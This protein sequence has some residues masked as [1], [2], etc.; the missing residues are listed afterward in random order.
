MKLNTQTLTVLKSFSGIN[1]NLVIEPGNTI[2]TISPART[3]FAKASVP[4]TFDKP[5]LIFDLISFLQAITLFDDA[6]LDFHDKFVNVKTAGSVIKYWYCDP[7]VIKAPPNKEIVIEEEVFGCE[8]SQGDINSLFKVAAA[9][10]SPEIIFKS[11]GK[12]A[13]LVVGDRKN[14]TANNYTKELGVSEKVFNA[15]LRVE[16]FKLLPGDYTVKIAK[17]G[18]IGIV[19]FANKNQDLTYWMMVDTDSKF[20]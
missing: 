11:D 10:G 15:I 4:D 6:D 19:I 12:K 13:V 20:E 3:V 8:L 2:R 18:T 5:I 16:N 9:L 17:K 7:Q 1:V 14:D